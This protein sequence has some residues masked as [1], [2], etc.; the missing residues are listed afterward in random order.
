MTSTDVYTT[1]D[2]YQ[3]SFG[4]SADAFVAKYISSPDLSLTETATPNP[5]IVNRALTLALK[6]NNNSGASFTGVTVTDVLPVGARFV[7]VS[8]SQGNCTVSAGTVTCQLG[9]LTS[10]ASVT[11]DIEV[12]VSK[13]GLLTNGATLTASQPELNTANNHAAVIVPV[14][15]GPRLLIAHSLNSVVISWATAEGY[16]LETTSALG[17]L[18]NWLTITNTPQSTN[19][20]ET[21]TLGAPSTHRFFR[22]A[23]P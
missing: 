16:R 10:N 12:A 18:A 4:G 14:E 6:I 11:V 17:P 5:V 8:A 2:A 3:P 13:A 21:V 22:L 23:N 7:S 20:Q 1:P 19:G 9:T 15:A